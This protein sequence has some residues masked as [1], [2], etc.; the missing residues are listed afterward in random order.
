MGRNAVVRDNQQ[1]PYQAV[2]GSARHA[3]VKA[4]RQCIGFT[5]FMQL[6]LGLVR[7]LEF[8]S[9]DAVHC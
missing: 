8:F 9:S 1:F 2:V 4:T 7:K 3:T 6:T 5:L